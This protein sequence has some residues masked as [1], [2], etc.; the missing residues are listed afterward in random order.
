MGVSVCVMLFSMFEEYANGAI[1][2][3][4]AICLQ[5]SW[6]TRWAQ[7]LGH[8]REPSDWVIPTN[9]AQSLGHHGHGRGSVCSLPLLWDA[10]CLRLPTGSFEAKG[11]VGG[12]YFLAGQDG[13]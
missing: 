13:T 5:A 1:H 7:S 10:Q 11:R 6:Q 3:R 4:H 2:A 12:F 8:H 9:G